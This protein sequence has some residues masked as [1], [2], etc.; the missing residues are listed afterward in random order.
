MAI[1]N[2]CTQC[3]ISVMGKESA[4]PKSVFASQVSTPVICLLGT[5][6]PLYIL[7]LCI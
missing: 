1:N 4:T 7:I 2:V 5:L 3:V 6:V